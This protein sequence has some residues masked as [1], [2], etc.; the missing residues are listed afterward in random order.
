MEFAKARPLTFISVPTLQFYGSTEYIYWAIFNLFETM[1]SLK[2]ALLFLSPEIPFRFYYFTYLMVRWPQEGAKRAN[3]RLTHYGAPLWELAQGRV[4]SP[5]CIP[6]I[7]APLLHC[8]IV[9]RRD[10]PQARK[11]SF[12][13]ECTE[14]PM[15]RATPVTAATQN[16]LQNTGYYYELHT[17]IITM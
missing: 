8:S 14:C 9:L 17:T 1:C 3:R 4:P 16:S 6:E 12:V 10:S 5:L 2:S 7:R 11:N 15:S 13:G